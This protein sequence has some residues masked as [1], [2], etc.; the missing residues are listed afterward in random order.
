MPS[1]DLVTFR[2]FKPPRKELNV[3]ES[4]RDKRAPTP[5]KESVPVPYL[6]MYQDEDDGSG[7]AQLTNG[8]FWRLSD[9][10]STPELRM[11]G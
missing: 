4:L 8:A 6:C 9:E 1:E 2:I 11:T 7:A 5:S 3:N 10:G